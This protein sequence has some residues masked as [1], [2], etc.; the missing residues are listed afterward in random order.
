MGPSAIFKDFSSLISWVTVLFRITQ[1]VLERTIRKKVVFHKDILRKQ[2]KFVVLSVAKVL[3]NDFSQIGG[4]F[5]T[6]SFVHKL[7]FLLCYWR[8]GWDS[9]PRGACAPNVNCRR[10]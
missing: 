5:I 8:R 4:I 3:R 7:L 10:K 2:A 1:L 9:N 6:D